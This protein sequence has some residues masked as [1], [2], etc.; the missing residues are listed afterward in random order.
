MFQAHGPDRR[1]GRPDEDD[2]GFRTGLC[3]A[4]MLGQEAISRME[5]IGPGPRS[6]LHDPV[7]PQVGIQGRRRPDRV[8]FVGQ[9][10]VQG[11]AVGLRVDR[12]RPHSEAPRRAQDPASDLAAIGDEDGGEGPGHRWMPHIRNRP[13]RVSSTGALRQADR[14]SP[15][16]RRVSSGRMMPSSQSRA[17]A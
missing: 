15:S 3:E 13:K 11:R 9:G 7:D 1:G 8:G 5:A 17:V 4:R 16:T 6:G 10:Y 12:D 14:A 2:A